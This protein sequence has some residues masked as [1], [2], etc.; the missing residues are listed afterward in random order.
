MRTYIR[1]FLLISIPIFIAVILG[2]TIIQ[3]N[4]ISE[5]K[6][7]LVK[8]TKQKWLIVKDD[9]ASVSGKNYLIYSKY[10]EIT[11]KTN[12]RFT[13]IDKNG[14]VILDST[15]AYEK[16][17]Q[18]DNHAGR[19]EIKEALETGTGTVI[20]YSKTFNEKLFYYAGKLPNGN[21]LR[22]AYPLSYIKMLE[23]SITMQM[24]AIFTAL[25]ITIVIIVALIAQKL[26]LPIQRLNYIAENVEKGKTNIHFPKFRDP[27]MAKIAAL[28]YKI[29]HAMLNKQNT[30]KAEQ[31][32][33]EH[34]FSIMDEGILLTDTK[35]RVIHIN[36]SFK[37]LFD[38][39]VKKGDNLLE[40]LNDAELI[41]FFDEI[42]QN[43]TIK[44]AQFPFRERIFEVYVNTMNEQ[45]LTILHDVTDRIKYQLFKAELTGNIS[46]ELKTPISMIMNYAETLM[47]ND[48]LDDKTR[49]KFLK[50][51]YSS[52]N[53]LNE[54]INDIVELHKLESL[55]E[56]F[57]ISEPVDLSELKENMQMLYANV[58]DKDISFHF[59]NT[60]VN[61]FNE[62]LQS[63]ITNLVDNAI[64]Y[65]D[66]KRIG[67]STHKKNGQL[68]ITVDDE[69]PKIAE[70][71]K[72]RI[73]ERFYTCSK[74]RNKE[75]SGTGLGLSIVKHIVDLYEGVIKLKTNKWGGNSF[76]IIMQEKSTGNKR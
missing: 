1:F 23:E 76:H 38:A 2:F 44:R 33:L 73:F 62:H 17:G 18:L 15:V 6:Q 41:D 21:I 47:I 50:T 68:Y 71:D 40:S 45:K 63:V 34:I 64:K 59:D 60:K 13:L 30:L 67:V 11:D 8:E 16:I 65:S 7:Q 35:N 5:T 53:R 24:T 36:E 27:Q 57:E 3:K 29:F 14:K 51:I 10:A 32:K 75:K 55:G 46:H 22:I 58:E 66:G 42:L 31:E 26:S 54:L 49:K 52:T 9:F 69:G 43:D 25:L 12:L 56:N 4:V 74:S 28:I 20:R 37:T 48:D 72:K 19:P 61:F 39:D 70:G